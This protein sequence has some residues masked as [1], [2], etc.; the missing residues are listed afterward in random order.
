MPR[1]SPRLLFPLF[2][3]ILLSFAL[4]ALAAVHDAPSVSVDAVGHGKVR[5]TITAGSSGAPQG[6]GILW[7]KENE[8]GGEWPAD[9]SHSGLDWS[10]FT[11]TPTLNTFD[12]L[13]DFALDPFE[14]IQIEIGDLEGE[15]GIL[16]NDRGEL[17]SAVRYVLTAFV[18][19]GEDL[20]QSTYAD[21]V[22]AM[23]TTQGENCTFTIGYW[24]THGPGD[25]VSGNNANEWP[26][27]GLT[28]GTVNYTDL[29]L[30]SILTRTRRG[31]A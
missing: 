12:Q 23:P 7:M 5:L 2:S 10:M 18:R 25:C 15:T 22:A 30:C 14:S 26:V 24:K 21:N 1:L 28:L 27:A 20:S 6:F 3:L 19:E 9:L 8:F 11:G 17:E 4:P 13:A 29:E 31:T 16:S